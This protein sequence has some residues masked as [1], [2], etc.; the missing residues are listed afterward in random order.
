MLIY[1][2]QK[3]ITICKDECN[4]D[5]LQV[6][7]LNWQIACSYLTYTAFKLYL[8]LAGNKN[9][10]TF[11][12]S[13]EAVNELIPMNRK[14]YDKAVKELKDCGYLRQIKRNAWMFSDKV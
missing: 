7:N 8:Y 6:N 2:N 5:F 14:S 1:P 11:A 13:Y 10:Y 3:V 12:L 9:G 4:S